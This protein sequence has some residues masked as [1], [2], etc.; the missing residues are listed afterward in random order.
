MYILRSDLG[1]SILESFK[2]FMYSICAFI[3]ELIIHLYNLFDMLCHGRLMDNELMQQ[4]SQRI[5]LILGL[6]MFFRVAFSF[7]QILIN[8]DT[9]NDKEKGAF[10]IV[11][12]VLIVIVLLGTTSYIFDFAFKIQ[13]VLLGD[14]DDNVNVIS[15]LLLPETVDTD[16][17]GGA[18]SANL[19]L[20]FYNLNPN[21]EGLYDDDNDY[22]RCANYRTYL[23]N[24]IVNYNSFDL[25]YNCLTADS[26][27]TAGNEISDDDETYDIIEFNYL[28]AVVVG[29][30]VCWML[31]T[32]C[33]SVG[34]RIIQLAFL[35]IIAP[36]PIISYISPKKDGMFQKWA[37]MCLTTY[38]DVF[39]RVAIINFV[40]LIIAYI[41][42]GF[43]NSTGVFW[44]SMLAY[45]GARL[46]SKAMTF[47]KIIIILAL[48][49]FAKKAPELIKELLP[50]SWVASGDFGVGL[51]NRGVLGQA[52][53]LAGGVAA[54]GAIGL[55]SGV[56][57]GK[58]ISRFTGALGGVLGGA[59]RGV[60]GGYKN[61]GTSFG[62]IT[63][64]IGD[65][66]KKQA[67]Y[68]LKRAQRIASGTG[69]G[70]RIGDYSR[71]FFGM[72]S[73]YASFDAEYSAVQ[74]AVDAVDN[75]SSTKKVK[76]MRQE[77]L[78]NRAT[79]RANADTEY[80]KKLAAL[81]SDETRQYNELYSKYQKGEIKSDQYEDLLSK[82]RNETVEAEN[83]LLNQ[84]E[85]A[86]AAADKSVSEASD[87]LSA[88]Q[89]AVYSLSI[90]DYAALDKMEKAGKITKEG[91][92]YF[93]AGIKVSQYDSIAATINNAKSVSKGD[94]GSYDA[95]DKKASA[96]SAEKASRHKNG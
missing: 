78:R 93:I 68:G 40:V 92:D 57:G 45:N 81:K 54:G 64:G 25:G 67:D 38:L 50:K 80:G 61:K 9:I 17:F 63:K 19:F 48:L 32:Y 37:K 82:L 53:A 85:A 42:N 46:G 43:E 6:V 87:D 36:M 11:K 77:A 23:R 3:Y 65:V 96:L 15:R 41:I 75:A 26:V 47:L 58:G 79:L 95:M 84:R 86:Y 66:R 22:I 51:K 34:V 91:N 73:G 30:F 20:S 52:M 2:T 14:N 72:Q 90:K 8:P 21:L 1:A 12:N 62:D 27:I 16:N 56:A 59:G 74:A 44:E 69:L 7:I 83:L 94:L 28:L 55:V 39:I 89:E 60:I 70:E 31:L 71:G 24:E 88:M 4:F 18:F 35:E 13:N 33:F 5:G 10:S 49:Q 29:V 76:E